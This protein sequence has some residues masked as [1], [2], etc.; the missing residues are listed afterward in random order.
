MK[1]IDVIIP[2]RDRDNERIQRCIN[3]L[4]GLPIQD[5][6]VVDYGSK[7]PVD[8]KCTKLIRHCK[9]PIWNKAHA[10][11]LGIKATHSKYIM[12]IDCDMILNDEIIIRIDSNLKAN[13]FIYNSNVRRVNIEDISDDYKLMLTKSLPWFGNNRNQFYSKANGGIQVY[14]RSFIEHVGGVDEEFGVYFGAMDN[15]VYEQAC[16]ALMN[17]VNINYPMLHQEHKNKKESNLPK[18]ERELAGLI[19]TIKG[20]E[21]NRLMEMNSYIS[22]KPWGEEKPYQD[23][24]IN[25]AKEYIE[26]QNKGSKEQ[27]AFLIGLYEKIKN[28]K[29]KSGKVIVD[30]KDFTVT[31]K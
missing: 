18:E 14:P 8:V 23:K 17:E 12:T 26:F 19:R 16:M 4:A 25:M 1:Q 15:R 22:K 28:S 21:L 10:I 13:N 5:V 30:G 2:V 31:I 3:S 11:N 6:V 20:Q 24:Y 7:V 27:T 29:T 9:N